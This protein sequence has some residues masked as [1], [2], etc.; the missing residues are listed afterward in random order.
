M[1]EYYHSRITG[2]HW[3]S[4]VRETEARC[5]LIEK[6]EQTKQELACIKVETKIVELKEC[7]ELMCTDM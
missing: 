3:L 2:E 4:L 5:I 1:H 7:I 6:V